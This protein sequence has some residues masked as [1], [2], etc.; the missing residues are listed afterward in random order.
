MTSRRATVAALRRRNRRLELERLEREWVC[1]GPLVEIGE[2]IIGGSDPHAH[3]ELYVAEM[4]ARMERVH[5]E[6]L[7]LALHFTKRCLLMA[8]ERK[9]ML[10]DLLALFEAVGRPQT[11]P[12]HSTANTI[13]V[14]QIPTL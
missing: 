4:K 9:A 8:R 14:P 13:P 11:I 6:T 1:G 3:Y 7:L 2:P 10:D 5:T 12:T